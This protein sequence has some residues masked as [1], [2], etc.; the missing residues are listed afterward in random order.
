[1][2]DGG[3]KKRE[4]MARGEGWGNGNCRVTKT[5]DVSEV[6]RDKIEVE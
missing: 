2:E 3:G 1:M 6:V 4:S 5:I